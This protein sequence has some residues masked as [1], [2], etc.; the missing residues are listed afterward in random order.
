M[1]GGYAVYSLMYE[2]HRSWYSFIVGTLAG[3]VYTFG[4]IMMTP[5]LFIKC[6]IN[7]LAGLSPKILILFPQ[8]QVEERRSLAVARVHL[9]GDV[10]LHRRYLRLPHP[11]ADDASPSCLP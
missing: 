8:L 4:F 7:A 11:H 1:V 9:Q 10:D 2:T 5:Q 6:V 3:V